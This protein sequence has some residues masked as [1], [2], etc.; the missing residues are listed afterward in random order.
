MAIIADK[1]NY[2][3]LDT[4]TTGLDP[5]R[6]DVI[7]LACIPVINGIRLDSFF[8]EFC[9][10]FDWSTIDDKALEI[11]H[12]TK[13]D[14]T[15]FQPPVQMVKKFI[16]YCKQ[17]G[18]KFTIAGYNAEF[19]KNFLSSLFKKCGLEK[20]FNEIF[21]GD[22][23]DLYKRVKSIKAQL[24]TPN[25]KLATLCA[26]YGITIKAHDAL[27]DIN[28]TINLDKIISDML[29]DVD[30][31]SSIIEHKVDASLNFP[32]PIHL[33]MHSKYSHTDSL[34]SI[35]SIVEWC[36]ETKTPGFSVVDHG[37]AAS[38][39]EMTRIGDI[40]KSI[41]KDNKTNHA[42]N[43]IKAIP[44]VGLH[45]S[46]NNSL[47]FLNAWAVSNTGYKNLVKLASEGW[48]TR[49]TISDVEYPV[50]SL[51]QV[52]AKQDGIVFGVPGV[53]G[54]FTDMI[55]KK[56]F[57]AITELLVLLNSNINI[58]L[59]LAALDVYKYFD[60]N[61]GFMT[62]NVDGG[63]IQKS[64]NRLYFMLAEKYNIKCIPVSDSHYI[65]P[66][67]K[68]IQDCIS[69]NSFKDKRHFFE[70]RHQLNSN[71]M[72]TIL[73]SHIGGALT[74][75]KYRELIEN[76]Y[77]IGGS[78]NISI[79]HDFHLPVIDISQ[80]IKDRESN[81]DNQTYMFTL[82]K[83]KEHGRWNNSPEYIERF[84]KEIDVIMKND[85]L[86]FLPYFLMYEDVCQFARSC[87]LLQGIAR[88]SAGGSLL[89]YYLKIIHIDP[90]AANL[91]FE[92][93]LSHAR[94]RAGSF[95]DIDLDIADRARP[96]VMKYLQEKYGLGFA[97]ISTFQ[98]MKT[99]N[100]IKDSMAALY[101]R[102]RND[103]E[104]KA[105]CD[106]IPDSPQGLDEWD[107]LYGYT[108]QEGVDHSGQVQTNEMLKN[109]FEQRPE[110][111]KMV[112]KLIGSIRGWSRHAS[113]FVISTI[114]LADGRVPTMVMSD[115][116]LGD[117][118]VTQ[119][120]APMVEKSGL[121]K[122][123]I[124]GLKTLTMTSDCIA[125]IK[126]TTGDDLLEETHGVP[127]VYRLPD[128]DEKVFA[129]FY[130]RDTDSSFQ[131]N[132]GVIKGVVADFTPTKK[133]H[134]SIMTA[135]MR[136]GAMDAQ[137]DYIDQYGEK[138]T[139]SAADFYI[140]VRKGSNNAFY[141]HSDL[142]PILESTY[143]V[144]VYQEQVMQILVDICGYSMEE[145]DT[146]RSA[147]AKKKHEVI[148]E[149]FKR[150]RE[151]T[152][153]RGWN[154]EQANALCQQIQA[155]SR[156]SFNKSHSHAYAELGYI[157]MYLKT[158][159][160]LEWWCS[161]LNNEDDSDKIRSYIVKL[162]DKISP[163]SLK[164][165]SK[166]WSLKDGKLITP[167]SAIK[168]IG[169]AVVDELLIKGPFN[170]IEDYV[171]RVNH[172]KVNIG[173]MSAFIKA[174][175]ADD[176]MDLSNLDYISRRKS[177]MDKYASLRKSKTSFK[178]E[179]YDM[180]Y[181]SIFLDER[182]LNEAFNKSLLSSPELLDVMLSR[183]PGLRKTGSK[184]IPL[185]LGNFN[186]KTQ[187]DDSTYIIPDIKSAE[188]MLKN[189]GDKDFGII[190]LFQESS[191]AS[192]ISKKSGKP[193]QKLSVIVSDG[194][195]TMECTWWDKTKPLRF[196]K[197]SIVFIRGVLK[198]GWKTPVSMQIKEIEQVG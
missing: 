7:Q 58:R 81:Y 3:W 170:N 65:E 116:D 79:K 190:A 181:L 178:P 15:D 22:L 98:K 71:E 108:D 47:F 193:W 128:K 96:M 1:I 119:F 88:G 111:E 110:I 197:N 92:R 36:L 68:V 46:H 162:T 180:N 57:N 118:I 89:S 109:F 70:S 143:G 72:Y 192:G 64:I 28:A 34:P 166:L 168:G 196:K 30:I 31:S 95:P 24:P 189:G 100:A 76:T 61:L 188:I 198:T 194:Y 29:G 147:I 107:F 142:K 176:M 11:N 69:K 59:E 117:I 125:L 101:G 5:V 129:D 106:M 141:I 165:P 8:N 161:V 10:P 154:E 167:I 23:R 20:E 9:Q 146:I 150:I 177:F 153:Q 131:F 51:E 195:N 62:Y 184:L 52:F 145:T 152:A 90:V 172:S 53:N 78:T 83:I 38:L 85:T 183:W 2:L 60:S 104:V 132:S 32:E 56:N 134:L 25:V 66:S 97:Q 121:V 123:D 44:G 16:I 45:V 127:L 35:K 138:D 186:N 75:S 163:P 140:S 77:D 164:N 179:M 185:A 173:A 124:L 112:Q 157:T 74:E 21:T 158:H 137:M 26:H 17:Y 144:I 130:K 175:A 87:G 18:V 84:K 187:T 33:H 49:T 55:V 171:Q 133:E 156:Y 113:A 149:A 82:K 12:I 151:S 27:S 48:T 80:D 103:P 120:D 6:N 50:L 136:P 148:M 169:P 19:D 42:L 4:E 14:L 105:I 155:F 139:M 174:R 13:V 126:K 135:L 160:P 63:N 67:E 91:P 94:I 182:E 37:M 115:K 122:A 40:I 39:F 159:Y 73:K 54:P 86:N 191:F 114:D 41:N 102:N 93:F 43:A 99:K